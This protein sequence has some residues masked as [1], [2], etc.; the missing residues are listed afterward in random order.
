M[1]NWMTG[2]EVVAIGDIASTNP[3]DLVHHV[4]LGHECYKLWVHEVTNFEV[5]LYRPTREFFLLHEALSSTVTW[6]IKYIIF[7]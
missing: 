5:T 2:S 6:P 7:N 1:L 4:P 3:N